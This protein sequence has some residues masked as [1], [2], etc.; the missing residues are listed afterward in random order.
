MGQDADFFSA[1]K[2]RFGEQ[3]DS[4][5]RLLGGEAELLAHAV[6]EVNHLGKV[7][8]HSDDLPNSETKKAVED[9]GFIRH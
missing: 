6:P 3:K 7:E 5:S 1:V 2:G 8:F 4:G 9:D